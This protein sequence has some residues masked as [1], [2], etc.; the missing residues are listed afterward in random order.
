MFHHLSR[1]IPE[2]VLCFGR[3]HLYPTAGAVP[4]SPPHTVCSPVPL[5]VPLR[6]RVAADRLLAP[7]A[8]QLLDLARHGQVVGRP[9]LQARQPQELQQTFNISAIVDIPVPCPVVRGRPGVGCRGRR[10]GTPC[11][12]RGRW[13]RG[14]AAGRRPAGGRSPALP[15]TST[16]SCT[17][18]SRPAVQAGPQ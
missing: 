9:P 18:L 1:F 4:P 2:D 13:W 11:P 6:Q 17:A 5:F 16:P 7:V 3:Y 8:H 14:P 15:P 12:G 10:V